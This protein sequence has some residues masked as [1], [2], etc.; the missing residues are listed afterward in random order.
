MLIG[1]ATNLMLHSARR[2]PHNTILCFPCANQ[3]HVLITGPSQTP[4]E[5][6]MFLF[7]VRLPPDY[8][9]RPPLVKLLTTGQVG[10]QC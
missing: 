3:M 4:Y 5:G 9:L 1:R 2:T 8:P 6:G 10:R 7:F